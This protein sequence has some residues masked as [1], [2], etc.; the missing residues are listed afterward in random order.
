MRRPRPPAG[1]GIVLEEVRFA[2]TGGPEMHFDACIKA[3]DVVAIMG[4]SGS[5]KTTLLDLIAGFARPVAGRIMIGDTD[6]TLLPPHQ[7][8]VS[9]IFQENN[10]FSHLTVEQNVGLGRSPSLRLSQRDRDEIAAALS[11]TGLEGKAER[12]PGA[13]SGGERQRVALARVLVRKNPVLLLDE[14]LASLGPALRGEMLDLIA[15]LHAEHRMTILMVTHDPADAER[16]SETLLFIEQG[17]IAA[18]GPTQDL[19]GTD[20]PASFK[21]YLGNRNMM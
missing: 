9:M 8:P 10:L 7:R 3:G 11:Q 12:L 15:M 4:P 17:H 1:A 21:A 16:L 6:V 5:G 13:L 2:H 18:T 19:L 20:A 14:A